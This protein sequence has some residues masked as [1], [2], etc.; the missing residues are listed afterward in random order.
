MSSIVLLAVL[1]GVPQLLRA[2]AL[3]DLLA[4]ATG[5][6]WFVNG[7]TGN[8]GNEGTQAAP[9]KNIDRAIRNAAA[10][11]TIL[12]AGGVYMGTFGSG[13]LEIDKPLS[14]Y[15]GF[16]SDFS[17]R[18]FL[19]HPTFFQP[20]NASAAKTRD[21]LVTITK[22]IDGI[23]I[24]GFV[25]DMGRRN[26]YSSAKGQPEG[27]ETGMLLLPPAKDGNDAPTVEKPILSIPSATQGG[28]MTVRN[29]VF[30]N[31]ANF[32]IQAGV[33]SGTLR[34]LNNVFVANRMAA[35]EVYG[36]AAQEPGNVEIAHNTI[37]FTWS[38][39]EDFQDMGYGIRLMTK[40][41]YDIHDNI[42]G[43]NILGGV[44]HRRFN[45]DE[46]IKLDNNIFFVNKT[47]DFAYSPGSN[48]LFNLAAAELSDVPLASVRGN[49]TEIPAS[50][51]VDKAYLEGYL[52][53][54]YSE[55][56][57]LDRDSPANQWRSALGMNLVGSIQTQVTMFANRYPVANALA[58][59]GAV[60]GKGAQKP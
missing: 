51:P 47:A 45:K 28:D 22:S 53:A 39:L 57:S 3:A 1:L 12:V 26:S 19:A 44:E 38:R 15:G 8:N 43:G 9:L 7:E 13:K 56:T 10:G 31:G 18:D 35:I 17:A 33:R 50:L 42:I 29:C 36:T 40:M 4:P 59:F 5:R 37:L 20:D 2:S 23:V 16:A 25:F 6:A 30:A 54:R 41:R 55:Q 58:M 27:V 52:G 14:L 48:E 60:P 32:G 49:V 24:D 11:D 21:A 46:W 34:I